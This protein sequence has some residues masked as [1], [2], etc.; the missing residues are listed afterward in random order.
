MNSDNGS[1][2]GN[3]QRVTTPASTLYG[4][5]SILLLMSQPPISS[6]G[7]VLSAADTLSVRTASSI[8][9]MI[10]GNTMHTSA[11]NIHLLHISIT[12]IESKMNYDVPTVTDRIRYVN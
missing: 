7:V 4:E 10:A 3:R 9:G 5:K 11:G 2:R 6:D 1:N 8:I 12:S